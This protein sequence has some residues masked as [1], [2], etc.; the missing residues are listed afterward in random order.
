ML[1]AVN[2]YET[3]ALYTQE[4]IKIYNNKKIGDM[5]PHIFAIADNAFS[6]M[7]TN[8]QNQSIVIRYLCHFIIYLKTN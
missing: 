3:L 4:K 7:T 1:V 6:S 2:P 8:S 5:P